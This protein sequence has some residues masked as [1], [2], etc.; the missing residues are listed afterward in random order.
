MLAAAAF[1]CVAAGGLVSRTAG[2]A[3]FLARFGSALLPFLY[4]AGG[5]ATG[6]AA[7]AC[8]LLARRLPTSRVALAVAV[9][10]AAADVALFATFRAF[11]SDALEARRFGSSEDPLAAREPALTAWLN[12]RLASA[13]NK[14]LIYLAAVLPQL[15]MLVEP[16]KL[17]PALARPSRP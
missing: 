7:F 17:E 3:L 14:E 13:P 15:A 11:P 9:L 4:L 16:S 5:V 8:V 12:E 10:L 1:V 6:L 2:D